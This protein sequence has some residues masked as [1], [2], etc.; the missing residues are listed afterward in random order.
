MKAVS[1]TFSVVVAFVVAAVV[2][3]AALYAYSQYQV[4]SAP[5]TSSTTTSSGPSKV[6]L[7]YDNSTKTVY[8]KLVTL[9][10]SSSQFNFNGTSFGS[11]IIYV[12]AGWNLN[13]TYENQESL[14]HNL[15]LVQNNTAIPQSGDIAEDG[16]ILL[17]IGATSS[18]YQLQGLSGGQSASGLYQ[19]IAPGDYWF[20]CGITGHA[21]SG[22]WVDVV[23][24]PSVTQPYVVVSSS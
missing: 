8:I 10:S 22:M 15:N 14:P 9:S 13:I 6:I 12:P 19:D 7:P 5:P 2:L 4:L 1:Q 3:A 20:A 18:T 24:S 21:A 17:T 23:V 11:M 16:K